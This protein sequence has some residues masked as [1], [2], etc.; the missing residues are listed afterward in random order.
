MAQESDAFIAYLM[1]LKRGAAAVPAPARESN[2]EAA[3]GI[4]PA[5]QNSYSGA[6]KRRSLDYKCEGSAQ[7]C[8]VGSEVHT[9]ATF[10]NI[11]IHGGYVEA[12]ATYPVGCGFRL[13][14]EANGQRVEATGNVRVSYP[15]LGMGIAFLEITEENKARLRNMLASLSRPSVIIGPSLAS[16]L[17]ARGPLEAVPAIPDPKAGIQAF[18]D[19]FES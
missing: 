9:W 4:E 19:F 11:C 13:K 1:A 12:Q 6:E 15:Y 18:I 17:P 2:Y 10:T 7:M 3:A 14:L 5:S 8:E 16:T